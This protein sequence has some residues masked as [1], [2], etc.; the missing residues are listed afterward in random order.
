MAS[1]TLGLS[2]GSENDWIWA[3]QLKGTVGRQFRKEAQLFRSPRRTVQGV[4]LPVGGRTEVR[5]QGADPHC[6]RMA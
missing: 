3:H 5:D 4:E 1:L 2:T 6:T